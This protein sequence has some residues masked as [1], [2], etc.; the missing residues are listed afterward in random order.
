MEIDFITALG[1]LLR[2][3]NLRDA[4]AADPQAVA[5]KVCLR[6]SDLPAW[7][8]LV[9]AEVEAQATVLLRKR[10]DLVKFFAPETCCRAGKNLWPSF[11]QYARVNWPPAE[12]PRLLDTFEY[13]RHL[14]TRGFGTVIDSE[15]NRLDFALSRRR[16]ALHWVPLPAR[17]DQT[18]RGIQLFWRGRGRKWR[19]FFFYLAP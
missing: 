17:D 2:D 6:Q 19:E 3:G 16:V 4:F 15:W 11:Q 12:G 10:L 5:A 1:R 9:S 7:L 18:R 13:C 8:Q 14:R